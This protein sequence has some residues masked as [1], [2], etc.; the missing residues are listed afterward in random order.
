MLVSSVRIST[1]PRAVISRS[2][3]PSMRS[4]SIVVAPL[5]PG[6]AAAPRQLQNIATSVAKRAARMA[7]F[8]A[9][10][11]CIGGRPKDDSLSGK[12]SQFRRMRNAP[13]GRMDS[14]LEALRRWLAAQLGHSDFSLAPASEDAS[15]RRYFRARLPD[16][17]SYVVMD[18]PPEKEDCRPF[19]HVARLLRAA[20]L[21]APEVHAQDEARGFLLLTD[22]GTRSYLQA[23]DE[24]SAAHA[25]RDR[26]PGTLAARDARRHAAAVRRG[27][28]QARDGAL[29]RVV[30]RPPSRAAPFAGPA[31]R[32]G[33]C[34]VPARGERPGTAGGIRAPRLHAAQPDGMRAQPRRARFPGRGARADKLRHRLAAARRVHQLGRRAR[35]R[36]VRALLGSRAARRASGRCR[37]RRLLAQLRM[38]GA[39]APSQGARHLCAAELPRRQGEVPRGHAALRRLCA[40]GGAALRRARSARAALRAHRGA[41]RVNAMLLAAGRGERLRPLTDAL[42]KALVEVCGKPLAVRHLERL[43][44]AGYREV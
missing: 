40:R 5:P 21:N 32:T 18:A 38:D 39:A 36:L 3:T 6:S 4:A 27:A 35:A 7:C 22:L 24:R 37:F 20:G 44:A 30:P 19:V 29:P 42:P 17:R 14:R 26:S 25:R 31:C 41:G 2:V 13:T 11:S 12:I 9:L 23:L 8:R 10:R 16:G 34:V 33:R 28:A 43:A 15:F 1:L